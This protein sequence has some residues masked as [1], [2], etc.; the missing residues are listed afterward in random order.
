MR[1]SRVQPT[2]KP[3][4]VVRPPIGPDLLPADQPSSCEACA[5]VAAIVPVFHHYVS[6]YDTSKYSPAIYNQVLKQ[7]RQPTEVDDH[8]LR[9]AVWW[10][11]GHLGK[12]NIPGTHRALI[13]HV[14]T[15][16][17]RFV[18]VLPDDPA[19]AFERL[20]EHIG[21]A[22]RFVTIAFLLHLLYPEQIPIIDQHNFRAVN[23]LMQA[24]RQGW[25]IKKLP[26]RYSDIVLVSKFMTAILE[27]WTESET[28]PVPN[29][30]ELDRFLMMYGKSVKTVGRTK[31]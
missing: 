8:T 17:H 7:F 5:I 6:Q 18:S 16:W 27:A 12:A 25:R 26:S 9:D 31:R 29:K 21:D 15:Q 3:I 1:T 10:K 14:Q 4:S 22:N 23:S 2:T 28:H 24:A 30:S 13:Q 20:H 11:Y 19:S